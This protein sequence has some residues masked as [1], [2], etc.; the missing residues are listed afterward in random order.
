ML[1]SGE[2]LQREIS[3]ISSKVAGKHLGWLDN[4]PPEPNCK[5]EISGLHSPDAKPAVAIDSD[6]NAVASVLQATKVQTNRL[7]LPS[8]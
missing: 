8:G 1:S 7:E 2:N 5:T 6:P 3:S 4:D